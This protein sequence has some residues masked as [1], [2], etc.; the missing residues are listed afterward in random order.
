VWLASASN[1]QGALV[2]FLRRHMKVN[3]S[4]AGRVISVVVPKD[5]EEIT[6]EVPQGVGQGL[7]KE[8]PLIVITD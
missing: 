3:L 7:K 2:C 4:F 6:L 5:T 8:E 1:L